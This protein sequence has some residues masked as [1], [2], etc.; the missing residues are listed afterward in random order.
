MC[1]IA[2]T[3]GFG[4][5]EMLRRMTNAI[6][7]R[8]PDGMYLFEDAPVFLGST[9]LAIRDVAGG[10]QPM[11]NEGGSIVVVYNGEI[12]N[13]TDLRD[14]LLRRGHVLRTQCDTEVLPHMYE[15]FGVEFAARLNG[16]FAIALWDQEKRQLFLYRDPL[17]VKPLLYAVD[18]QRMAFGSE[19]KAILKSGLLTPELNPVALHLCMNVRYIP[20]N[21]SLFRGIDRLA[22]GHLVQVSETGVTTQAYTSIDWSADNTLSER[23]WLDG[24]AEKLQTAV[25]RQLVSDVPVGVSLSGGIDSSALVALIRRHHGGDLKTFTLGF[26][27]PTDENADARQVAAHFATNHH[28]LVLQEPALRHLKQAVHFTEEPKVNCLQ[29]FM[30]HQYLGQHV[31]VVLSGLG[32]DELFA[33]YDFYRYMFAV[34]RT[35]R[36]LPATVWDALA[37]PELDA[38][39]LGTARLGS[40]RFDLFARKL[41]WAAA[42]HD[43][44][45][46]YLL[47]RNAWDS[48]RAM[49]ERV[50]EP[51]FLASLIPR[52]R[53]FYTEY[54][55]SGDSAANAMRAEFDTK[56]INDLLHNE[57][58]MSMA[59]SVE[60]RVPI[61][62][63]EFVRFAARMPAEIRFKHGPK[64][65]LRKALRDI[66]PRWVLRKKKQGFSVNPVEQYDKDLGALAKD[67]LLDTKFAERR[68]FRR[69]FV[70]AVLKARSAPS[71]RWHYFMLWQMI[72][73][74]F[75]C[76]TFTDGQE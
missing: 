68:I 55:G 28:E 47:L 11:T 5:R 58:T 41:E 36:C 34:D 67:L 3:Y 6:A 35:R 52:T 73:F 1:G 32:G 38:A 20:G 54:F 25:V 59:S 10:R 26:N 69:S 43:G 76:Q 70:E 30:L 12:Y 15:E 23:D 2:G 37:K 44:C 7:H 46:Q 13:Y 53:D 33:G 22:P 27:E 9:R 60:S 62:D 21:Q 24:I 56:M 45:R 75:W 50:Y 39:A 8:G 72:G 31:K 64:G 4:T 66:L 74:E 19:A 16:I 18:G 49:L 51:E 17:G 48:N 65:M 63:L 61:L 57:D 29:L 14:D 42:M 71:L 40:P